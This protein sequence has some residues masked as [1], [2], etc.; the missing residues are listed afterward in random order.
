MGL[1]LVFPTEFYRDEWHSI[2]KEI[3]D[4]GEKMTPYSLKSFTNDYTEYLRIT[5]D[6]S[7]GKNLNGIVQ[8]DTYFLVNDQNKR[9]LGAINIR[10]SLNDYLFN[11]GGHIGYGIRPCERQKGY[12]GKMLKMA[13]DICKEKGMDKVLITCDKSNIASSKTML[14]NGALL[15][16]EVQEDDK[17]VQRYWITL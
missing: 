8:A 4:S 1:K 12:A 7:N 9:I 2:I 15:E 10:Y 11:Y 13:L 14:K 17:I 3:E 5:Q 16:N 6:I